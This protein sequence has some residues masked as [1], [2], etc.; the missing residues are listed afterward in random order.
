MQVIAT[1][2]SNKDIGNLAAYFSDQKLNNPTSIETALA[3][4]GP[5]TMCQGCHGPSAEGQGQFPRLAGQQ[6]KYL[7]LQLKDFKSGS[8][9]NEPMQAI[10][11]NLSETDMKALT[12]YFGA[13]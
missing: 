9:K 1:N 6:A 11:A 3:K 8:R 12:A 4:S 2:L 5:A 10:S 7:E 13:L